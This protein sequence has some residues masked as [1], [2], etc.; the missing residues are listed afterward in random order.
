MATISQS[1]TPP[2][3]THQPPNPIQPTPSPVKLGNDYKFKFKFGSK[4]QADGQFEHPFG[5][6]IDNNANIIVSDSTNQRI[7]IFNSNGVFLRKFGSG[8]QADGQ[9]SD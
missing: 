2:L 6:A 7:Q 5:V 1:L 3:T 4:G 9:F 8:G